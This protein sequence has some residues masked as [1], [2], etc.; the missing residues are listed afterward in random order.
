MATPMSAKVTAA[1]TMLGSSSRSKIRDVFA[2]MARAATTNSRL[3]N[4][5]VVAR[6]TRNSNGAAD[7]GEHHRELQQRHRLPERLDDHDGEQRGEGQEHERNRVE[8][9]VRRAAA[10]AGQEP[11]RA[12]RSR[13]R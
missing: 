3:A 4:D 8:D 5:N 9:G 11:E 10:V 6:M 1:G 2:P 12:H 7:E 13:A